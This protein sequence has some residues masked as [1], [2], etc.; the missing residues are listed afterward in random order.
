MSKRRTNQE[1]LTRFFVNKQNLIR[2]LWIVYIGE[3]CRATLSATATHDSHYCTY[4][5]HL[6]QH[7]TDKMV[8][9]GQGK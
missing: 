2:L 1:D 7:D 4:L 9:I 6:G 5:G 3:V 8:S